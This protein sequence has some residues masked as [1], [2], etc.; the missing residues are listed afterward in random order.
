M[1][2]HTGES[3]CAWDIWPIKMILFFVFLSQVCQVENKSKPFSYSNHRTLELLS[4]TPA[5]VKRWP[6]AG[7][8]RP[9][10]KTLPL[11][12]GGSSESLLVWLITF[13]LIT[14]LLWET[15]LQRAYTTVA[16]WMDHSDIPKHPHHSGSDSRRVDKNNKI[17]SSH[18][19]EIPDLQQQKLWKEDSRRTKKYRSC[20]QGLDFYFSAT[21]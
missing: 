7:V 8:Q 5:R 18:N 16:P 21:H 9:E 19:G 2:T 3:L 11:T 17:D 14:S 6:G 4:S 12:T 15:T 13:Q 10:P 20:C 1:T